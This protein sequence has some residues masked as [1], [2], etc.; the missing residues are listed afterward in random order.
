M[1]KHNGTWFLEF[2]FNITIDGKVISWNVDEF[3]ASH[4][5]TLEILGFKILSFCGMVEDLAKP[6]I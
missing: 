1:R 2:D 6:V 3:K 5:C 4:G